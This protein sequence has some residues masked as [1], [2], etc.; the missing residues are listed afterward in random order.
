MRRFF[1]YL[2]VV[3][4][5]PGAALAGSISV[6]PGTVYDV[7]LVVS[8]PLPAGTSWAGVYGDLSVQHPLDGRFYPGPFG[9]FS[10]DPALVR[11]ENSS[12]VEL[13]T[14]GKLAVSDTNNWYIA[15]SPYDDVNFSD[16]RSTCDVNLDSVLEGNFCGYCTPSQTYG[17]DV[18]ITIRDRN[19]CAKLVILYDGVPSYVLLDQNGRPVFLGK[20][21]DYNILGSRHMFGVLLDVPSATK[22]YVYLVRAHIFCGDGVC[23][24]GELRCS[25]CKNIVVTVSPDAADANVGAAVS[26]NGSARNNGYYP[27]TVQSLSLD[28]LS[29]DSNGI[30][31]SFA[32]PDGAPPHFI[33]T[34]SDWNFGVGVT[35]QSPGDY[36]L[37]VVISDIFG[38]KYYSNPFTIHVASPP[39]PEVN[40]PAAAPAGGEGNAPVEKNT[41]IKLKTG[42]YYIPWKKCISF[43]KLTGPDRVNAKLDENVAI[44]IFVQNGGTC[45]ENIDVEVNSS[46]PESFTVT[47]RV[48]SL[49]RGSGRTVVLHVIPKRPGLHTVTVSARGLVSINH[50]LQL[51]VSNERAGGASRNCRDDIA[52]LAPEKLVVQEGSPIGSIIVRNMGTCRDLVQIHLEKI[53]D[54]SSIP[55]DQKRLYLS[56]G[57]SYTYNIPRL[58]AGKYTITVTAGNDTHVSQITVTPRPLVGNASQILSRAGVAIFAILLLVLIFTAGYVRYKYLS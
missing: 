20:V 34:G 30:S 43:V 35:P 46:P 50:K 9:Y 38:S 31:Y 39:A 16:L 32:Y 41:A 42:G 6:F 18:N 26:F 51:F 13:I 54:G 3:S 4:F 28:V 1:L 40:V 58:A 22:E 24:P 21:G 45:D 19:Y 14:S 17:S 27:I 33:A 56:G 47:P 2:L 8:Y 11:E 15:V 52:I 10:I 48:F 49:P 37:R 25:D 23:D 36:T 7:N 12:S 44:D 57:E 29:G 5:F 55:I 53:L